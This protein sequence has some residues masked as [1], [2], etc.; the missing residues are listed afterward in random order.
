MW[1]R[2]YGP[3]SLHGERVRLSVLCVRAREEKRFASRRG[4][5]KEQKGRKKIHVKSTSPSSVP[6]FF[7]YALLIVLLD[8]PRCTQ[9][10]TLITNRERTKCSKIIDLPLAISNHSNQF[11]CAR[12]KNSRNSVYSNWTTIP[13]N[14]RSYCRELLPALFRDT[15]GKAKGKYNRMF[16]NK[17][18]VN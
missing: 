9:I 7:R 10:P 11:K 16:N 15:R 1:P 8:A 13:A 18:S 6:R 17:L 5:K 3:L 4:N 2:V 12:N 14:L